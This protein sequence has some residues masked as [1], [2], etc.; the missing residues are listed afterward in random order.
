MYTLYHTSYRYRPELFDII[1]GQPEEL[2]WP[3]L[4][5]RIMEYTSR[6]GFAHH[7]DG[8]TWLDATDSGLCELLGFE[9]PVNRFAMIDDGQFIFSW[10]KVADT[11]H[12][13]WMISRS[14]EIQAQEQGAEVSQSAQD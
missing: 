14:H 2:T 11:V 8:N 4:L 1:G 7:S 3:L 12:R 6:H 10:S 9:S 5:A 13:R